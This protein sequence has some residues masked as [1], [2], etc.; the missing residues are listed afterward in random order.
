MENA[1]CELEYGSTY[2]PDRLFKSA[3]R[4]KAAGRTVRN[5]DEILAYHDNNLGLPLRGGA[6]VNHGFD[7][8]RTRVPKAG[9]NKKLS[10]ADTLREAVRYIQYLQSLL[11]AESGNNQ[12]G[13]PAPSCSVNSSIYAHSEMEFDVYF[14]TSAT[15]SNTSSQHP[16]PVH[17]MYGPQV[18]PQPNNSGAR[19]FP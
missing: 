4:I 3:K 17:S 16:S 19:P 14:P 7:L 9:I 6:L 12:T 8:L 2:N 10:K 1:I 15:V 11:H 18:V 5:F 13:Y